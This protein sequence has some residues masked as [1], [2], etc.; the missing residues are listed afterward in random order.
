MSN[1]HLLPR[2]P[3]RNRSVLGHL[4]YVTTHAVSPAPVARDQASYPM[5]IFLEGATGFRQMDTF[6]VE[7][8]VSHAY[9]VVA[10]D[11]SGAA[12]VVVLPDGQQAAGLTTLAEFK[13]SVGSSYLPGRR[14]HHWAVTPC[15]SCSTDD[16][17][18]AATASSRREMSIFA[19]TLPSPV[20]QFA[21]AI[22]RRPPNLRS[23]GSFR[24]Q[25]R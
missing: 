3:A 6:Q 15:P 2:C 21:P 5:L 23:P 11:Q 19:V 16:C 10:L 14:T 22:W 17:P 12:A 7:H 20:S 4:Q 9:I 24:P 1:Q 25:D 18:C 8:L 13:A